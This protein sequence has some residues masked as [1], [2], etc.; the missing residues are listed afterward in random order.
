MDQ[1]GGSE[2]GGFANAQPLRRNLIEMNLRNGS[3]HGLNPPVITSLRFQLLKHRHR[4]EEGKS[5]YKDE[6]LTTAGCV[7]RRTTLNVPQSGAVR[8]GKPNAMQGR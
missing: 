2:A 8:L 4:E 6:A 5:T 3:Y 1:R 7:H